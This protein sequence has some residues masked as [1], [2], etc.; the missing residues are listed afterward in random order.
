M[1]RTSRRASVVLSLGVLMCGLLLWSQVAWG[2]GATSGGDLTVALSSLSTETLDP[3]L[4]GH[5]VK[6]YMSLIFD[7]VVGTTPDGKP[8]PDGGIA[9]GWE[10]THDQGGWAFDIRQ[11]VKFHNGD[12][13]TA[14]DVKAS[15][16]RG[17]SPIS[18][19]GYAG[20]LRSSIKEIEIANPH[21][22]IIH[23]KSPS[24]IIPHYL[25][26]ALSTEGVVMPKALA[27]ENMKDQVA[28]HPIGSGP[29]RFVEQVTGSHITLE[30]V[31][32]HWRIGTPKFKTITFR[33]VPEES[34]RIAMLRRGEVD[35]IDVSRERVTEVKR[36]G[37]DSVLRKDEAMLNIW[38]I[39][40]WEPSVPINDKRIREAMNLA[41]NRQELLETL[42]GGMGEIIPIPYGLSW[43]LKEIGYQIAEQDH[44]SYDPERAKKLLAEAGHPNGFTVDF[45]SF[46][47]PGL[48]EGRAFVEAVAGYWERIGIKSKIIPVDY[49][50]FRKKWVDKQITGAPGYYNIANR[51]WV[52]TFAL[53][54][55]QAYGPSVMTTV[56]DPQ[57]DAWIQEI[58]TATDE[59]RAFELLRHIFKRFRSEHYVVPLFNIHSPYA[60][61]KKVAG[62]N[63]GTVMYDFNLDDLARGK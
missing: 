12:E 14:E 44:Y 63:I 38:L 50:A 4:G 55:K 40:N 26:R 19:T 61:S 21:K 42:F 48:P 51:G 33:L 7:Y 54:E 2:Q 1:G 23:T 43:T 24:L 25:S 59:A 31:P 6:Y 53:L 47:L 28:R 35:I 32:N 3:A 60:V 22:L 30:A 29:Y 56:K 20:A 39:Q 18:T 11:G 17:I 16:L 49:A 9:P 58:L 8:S 10:M 13:L 5:I 62:W 37:F 34:A 41:I 46:L 52:G 36:A 27:G 45:H 15:I 57:S